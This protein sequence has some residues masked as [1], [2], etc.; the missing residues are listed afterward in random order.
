MNNIA[1][2][3]RRQGRFLDAIHLDTEVVAARKRQFGDDHLITLRAIG[4]LAASYS[5]QGR[6]EEAEPLERHV[7]ASLADQLGMQ[8]Q[9]A[10]TA[11]NNLS[12]TL[13]DLGKVEEAIQTIS[14]VVEG[15]TLV[16]G[17]DHPETKKSTRNLHLW[18][19]MNSL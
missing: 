3:Y 14:C 2:N 12:H 6:P 16:L 9:D 4:N 13:K 10:L 7:A 19:Q 5:L 8:N 17:P 15:R 11:Q 18:Q 1:N